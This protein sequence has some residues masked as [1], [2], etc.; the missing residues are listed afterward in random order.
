MLFNS[1]GFIFLFLPITFAAF[2]ATSKRAGLAAT[3]LVAASLFFYGWWDWRY[4]A[5]L[6][7]SIVVN[8]YSGRA[9][10]RAHEA[11]EA[12]RKRSILTFAIVFDLAVLGFFKYADFFLGS[13][14]GLGLIRPTAL[15]IILPLGVSFFTFTQIAFLVDA[16]RGEAREYS[17]KLYSLFV[18][19]FPHLIAGP[20]LHHKEMMPQ[21]AAPGTFRLQSRNIGAGLTIFAIG[22]VKK[23]LIADG[24]APYANWLFGSAGATHPQLL[25]A[26]SG[27]L[28]YT[29]QIYF[30]FSGYSDMAIGAGL[31]FN[32]RLPLNFSSPYKSA[33]IIAFWRRWHMTL[34]RFLRDYVYIPLGGN[35]RGRVR[36]HLNLFAT[37]LV[38]G[39]WHGAGWTFVAWGALHGAYL[40]VNHAWRAVRPGEAGRAERLLG[41]LVTFLAVVVGWVFFRA[42]SFG[43]AA[44]I[45][46]G[47]A[48][49]NG[50]DVPYAALQRLGAF[51]EALTRWGVA[52]TLMS[53]SF[54]LYSWLWIVGSAS[55]AFFAPNTQEMMALYPGALDSGREALRPTRWLWRPT[56]GWAVAIAL[57]SAI[58]IFKLPQVTQFLYFQF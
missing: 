49:L 7:G 11:G 58:G 9:I 37:M 19:F 43:S 20:I 44:R 52:P 41:W 6:L 21:F 3:V 45:L 23:T 1:Y 32:I 4:L 42:D 2:Y 14:S 53:G 10:A 38:G 33:N 18:T 31:L 28:A 26:W 13:L 34:S 15:H 12:G 39:L 29:F 48:G 55:I 35:R 46:G 57:V 16:A 54:T 36:R 56:G 17:F 47:M 30:D 51:G 40:I 5:L 24:I 50:V 22:L 25:E 8:F 27:A